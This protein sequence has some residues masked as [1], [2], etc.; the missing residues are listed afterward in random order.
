MLLYLLLGLLLLAFALWWSQHGEGSAVLGSG[1]AFFSY[2]V[3]RRKAPAPHAGCPRC[4][5]R[6]CIG[7]G[8]CQC[9]CHLRPS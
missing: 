8:V 2:Y 9:A 6:S 1:N 5:S 4:Q 7:A 3:K